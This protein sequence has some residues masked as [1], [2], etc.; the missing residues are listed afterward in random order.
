VSV[1]AGEIDTSVDGRVY[2]L[3]PGDN[4]VVPRWLP[5]SSRNPLPGA[6]AVVHVAFGMSV[7]ART[8]LSL[9]FREQRMPDDSTGRPGGERVT[10]LQSARKYAA[11]PNTE[12][13]DYFNSQLIPGIEMSGGWARFAPGGRLPAHY[14]DFDESICIVQGTALC[15][16]NQRRY[17]V[18]G[19]ATACVPRGRPHYFINESDASMAMI[20]VYAG[21]LPE[22]FVVTDECLLEAE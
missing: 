14:H 21:P 1:L 7:P 8:E 6:P 17:N 15:R 5:H 20:W 13:V 19:C 4:I 2:R 3:R 9:E 11:G 18:S 12:F 16:V 22:R 10:R